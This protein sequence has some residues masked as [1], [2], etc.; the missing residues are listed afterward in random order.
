[1]TGQTADHGSAR[2]E[3]GSAVLE[4]ALVLPVVL[5]VVL[6]VVEVALLARTQLEVVAA[7][8]EGARHAAVS[9][10]PADAVG[11]VRQALG[12]RGDAAAVSVSRPA[13][14]GAAA[15]VEV[16]L[17]HALGGWLGGVGVELTGRA[18]MRVE[19]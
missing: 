17:E 6:G 16:R 7:A 1:M 13:V 12:S 5:V 9:S 15:V 10:D 18:T 11:A 8:R 14:V 4:F 3:T 19:R 2:R